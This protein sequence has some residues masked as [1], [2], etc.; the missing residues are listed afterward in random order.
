M[1]ACGLG[2]VLAVNEKFYNQI[3]EDQLK[4]I[5]DYYKEMEE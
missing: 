2:P 5:I 1:G 4:D 3:D